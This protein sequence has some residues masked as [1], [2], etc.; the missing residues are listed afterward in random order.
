MQ[1]FRDDVG[2][3]LLGV[4]E[5]PKGQFDGLALD[6]TNGDVP[7]AQALEEAHVRGRTDFE[8]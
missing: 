6:L 4:A 1:V 5:A 3:V 2:R 8:P 7:V